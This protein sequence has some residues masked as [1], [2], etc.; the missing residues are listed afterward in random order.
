VEAVGRWIG[1]EEPDAN[2]DDL[3]VAAAPSHKGIPITD[4][5]FSDTSCAAEAAAHAVLF[6]RGSDIDDA[7]RST[8]YADM[9]FDQ[10]PFAESDHFR[11]WL[12]DF[13]VPA[14][15]EGREMTSDERESLREYDASEIL[16]LRDEHS[17][18]GLPEE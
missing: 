4:C 13:A 2:W 6:I 5:R 11:E 16:V 3:S 7:Y 9:A 8:V 14:A 15:F 1:G 10:S 12:L 17:A 18:E